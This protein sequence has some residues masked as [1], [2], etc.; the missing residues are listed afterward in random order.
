MAERHR[1]DAWLKHVCLIKQR[2]EAGDACRGGHVKI[3]GQRV[4]P[5]APVREGDVIE[6]LKGTTYHRVVVSGL[7]EKQLAK[8]QA[9]TMYIDQTPKQEIDLTRIAL[10]ERG[11]GRPTKRER[12]ELDKMKR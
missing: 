10:R 5:A 11:S 8:E 4:K 6:F 2:S 9:R 1:I 7:P 12:R 3:N